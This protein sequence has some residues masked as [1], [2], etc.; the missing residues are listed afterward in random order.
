[1][2]ARKKAW[3][4]SAFS[5][6]DSTPKSTSVI[7]TATPARRTRSSS[8]VGKTTATTRARKPKETLD[9]SAVGTPTTIVDLT[10]TE[11]DDDK[12]ELPALANDNWME[13]F[14]PSQ[15]D[16]LAIHPKKVEELRDW[17]RHCEAMR[18][19]YPAQM[20]LLTGPSGA[21]KTAT[22]RVLAQEFN[23]QI[24]EWINPVDCEVVNALGD[25]SNGN[26]YVGSQL[27]AFKSFLLRASRY[28]SLLDKQNKRLL[29]VEDFP[30]FLLNDGQTIFEELIDEYA[31]Y[32]KSPL[33]FI[34][35]DSKSRGLNISY[36]L[37]TDQLKAKH[38]ITH[39]SFNSIASTIMQKSMKRFCSLMQQDQNKA[40]YKVPTQS[41]V[42]SI[43][44]GAQGDIRN[45][46]IN[47]HFGSLKG[48][49][50]IPVKQLDV[51]VVSKGRKRKAQSTLKF[52]GRDESITLMHALGRVFNPKYNEDREKRLQHSPEEIAEAF[53]T[54]PK[55]F[56]NFIHANYLPH[57]REIEDVVLASND[58][59]LADLL[60]QEY[61][62]DSLAVGALNVAVRGC[63]VAN[64]SPISGWMPVRGPKRLNNQPQVTPLEQK[65]LGIGF[66]GIPK[67]K[68]AS[69]YSSFVKSIAAKTKEEF[70]SY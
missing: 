25:Q 2:S 9:A 16:E 30:N 36:K 49:P 4:A 45:A 68:Y 12:R 46:L 24:Q 5:Q 13:N 60:L 69:E 48:V 41:V 59:A 32:G 65:L 35:A 22:L 67:A 38:R 62:D 42:D 10:I 47:L 26:S 21:G 52:I 15:S 14:A 29:L 54:E 7:D 64:S 40:I 39:I 27:E 51:S 17:L 1:M 6:L 3:V 11:D 18:K 28:K 70:E 31:S 63:M 23:Y 56:I 34:V 57:F 66:A 53:S 58:I 33:V 61:R 55:N 37:F 20:C 44:V 8:T 43:V 50:N 19:K